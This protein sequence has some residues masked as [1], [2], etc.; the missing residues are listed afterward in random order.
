MKKFEIRKTKNFEKK[1]I[2][3]IM[4]KEDYENKPMN[5]IYS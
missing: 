1:N 5:F 3:L 4:D 2:H